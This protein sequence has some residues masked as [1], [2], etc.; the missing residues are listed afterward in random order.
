MI[1]IGFIALYVAL[2]L[3]VGLLGRRRTIGFVG[4]FVL[5]LLLTPTVMA[6]VLMM[7]L[8]RERA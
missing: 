6:L 4:T 3:L 5:S 7:G 2:S 8:P 1:Y